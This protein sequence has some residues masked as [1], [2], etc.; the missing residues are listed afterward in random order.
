[1]IAVNGFGVRSGSIFMPSYGAWHARLIVDADAETD[2]TGACSV[3][4]EGGATLAGTA[5]RKGE[6]DGRFEVWIVG[7]AGLLAT[8]LVGKFYSAA[9][10]RTALADIANESG[11]TLSSTADTTTT[12]TLLPKWARIAGTAGRAL[13]LLSK[14]LGVPW[15]IIDDGSIWVGPETWPTFGVT[16]YDVVDDCAID[17]RMTISEETLSLRPGMTFEGL[18]VTY[19]EHRISPESL[20]TELYVG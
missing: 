12:T 1:M 5:F 15:R 4:I 11:E 6:Y 3:A 10:V 20:R 17:G 14:Q 8:L 2:I 18:Q 16:D 19:V 13:G 9:P 7:G